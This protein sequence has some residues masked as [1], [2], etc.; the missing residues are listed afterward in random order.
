MSDRNATR[1]RFSTDGLFA[2]LPPDRA[3]RAWRDFCAEHFGALE[4]ELREGVRFQ[5]GIDGLSLSAGV[6]VGSVA[7]NARRLARTAA[8]IRNNP[9][10]RLILTINTTGLE[11]TVRQR[12]R[13]LQVRP[14]TAFLYSHAH[15]GEFLDLPPTPCLQ[16]IMDHKLLSSRVTNPEDHLALQARADPG[17]LRLLTS[18]VRLL[19]DGEQ[20]IGNGLADAAA[21]H[22]V[23]LATLVLGAGRDSAAHAQQHGVRAAR[24]MAVLR[25]IDAEFSD[26]TLSVT[27]VAARLGVTPRYVH[28]LLEESGQSFSRHLSE[29]RLAAARELLGDPRKLHL[30]VADIAYAV[31]F[32]DVSHF[33]RSFRQ[34]YGMKPSDARTQAAMSRF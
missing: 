13:E 22:L 3:A 10:D 16:L 31:G 26:A 33:N 27:S 24:R 6:A 29:R 30:K 8:T 28:L 7:L 14:G 32:T 9:D 5:G 18:Y 25:Q 2:D 4:V 12:G 15:R 20:S 21:S 19:L 34:R 17:A 1:T 23:D 11:C